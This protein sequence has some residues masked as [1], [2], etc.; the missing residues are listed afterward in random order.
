MHVPFWIWGS[1]LG[2]DFGNLC[3]ANLRRFP[4]QVPARVL[5][6][7][8]LGAWVFRGMFIAA[9]AVSSEGCGARAPDGDCQPNW[10][11]GL[12]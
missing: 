6:L 4:S 3:S 8:V 7:G 9:G 12:V 2:V 10:G 5:F 11:L 1:V